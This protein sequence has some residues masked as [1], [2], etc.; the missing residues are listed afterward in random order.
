MLSTKERA[1]ATDPAWPIL[2]QDEWNELFDS[3]QL[4]LD[5]MGDGPQDVGTAY[6][7]NC[8]IHL[9]IAL[10]LAHKKMRAFGG[11]C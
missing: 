6:M 5:A 2:T 3:L 4:A 8:V 11:N 9:R 7:E 1:R 10:R